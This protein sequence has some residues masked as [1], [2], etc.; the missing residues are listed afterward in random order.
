MADGTPLW[1]TPPGTL[2]IS[3]SATAATTLYTVP[4]G[5]RLWL[6]SASITGVGGAGT[7]AVLLTATPEGDSSS[8]SIIRVD[9][10][11]ALWGGLEYWYGALPI[12]AGG[13]IVSSTSGT[14]PSAFTAVINGWEETAPK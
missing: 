2:Y 12:A 5:R 6:V 3:R 4:T 13:T 1:S 10:G 11:N 8:R 14:A 9:F 7:G